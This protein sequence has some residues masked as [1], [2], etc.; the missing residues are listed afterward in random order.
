MANYWTE[1]YL[2]EVR[3]EVVH[4]KRGILIVMFKFW[5]KMKRD[6]KLLRW[7]QELKTHEAL[8]HPDSLMRQA[9]TWYVDFL[10]MF[11]SD[12]L[13]MF[14]PRT[15]L[16]L[17]P[18]QKWIKIILYVV[19]AFYDVALGSGRLTPG[20]RRIKKLLVFCCIS[21][22]NISNW[23]IN[24]YVGSPASYSGI[25]TIYPRIVIY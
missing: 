25:S 2:F 3:S 6:P 13:Q 12:L 17:L 15:V 4:N 14:Q 16:Q 22:W 10:Q 20:T 18:V 24:Q 23:M 21:S 9:R 1:L 11:A 7:D 8:P 19:N 5:Y